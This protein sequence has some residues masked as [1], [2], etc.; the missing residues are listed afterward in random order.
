MPRYSIRLL[1]EF[2]VLVDGREVPGGAWRN[3]RAAD[4]VKLLA[5]EPGRTLHR[6]H[7]M[8]LLWPALT[9]AAAG[10]N[11][12]KAL[13]LARRALGSDQAVRS[14]G[15]LL[16]LGGGEPVEVDAARFAAAA[17]AALAGGD[18]SACAAAADLYPGDLLPA[19]RYEEWAAEPRTRLRDLHLAVLKGAGRWERALAVD[20]ADEESHRALMGAHLEAGRRREAIRQFERLRDA[21]REL[22]GVGPDPATVALYERVLAMEGPP[23]RPAERAAA[24]IATG[25]VHLNRGEYVR[26]EELA[27]RARDLAVAARLN[28]ELGDASTL[29]ALA[30]SRTGGWHE[31]FLEEFTA[32]LDRPADLVSVYDAN[33]CLAE[34]HLGGADLTPDAGSYAARLLALAEQAD[35]LP[36]RGIAELM[37][38]EASLL[39]GDLTEA[40]LRLARALRINTEAGT[41]SGACLCLERLAQTALAE[42]D[43]ARAA[44]RLSE[45]LPRARTAPMRSHLLVRLLGVSV[46]AAPDVPSAVTAVRRAERLLADT[47]PTCEACALPYRVQASIACS[48]AGDLPRA[49]RH[50]ADAER[51]AALWQ[52]APWSA[53]LWEARAHLRAAEGRPAQAVAFLR[54]AAL[55]YRTA[56]RPADER[57]CLSTVL[58]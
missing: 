2:T 50:L 15:A 31:L 33:L 30:R 32:L 26:A 24:L 44:S 3:R 56:A 38:G 49:R 29:M 48:R 20:P 23:P 36:G 43:R 37:L 7:V 51:I 17:R 16:V 52:C 5:L 13:H 4:L 39:A 22:M 57:R 58:T 1:G 40:G 47:P 34:Y 35:S 21:L 14:E 42:G 27:R 55:A 28:H 53:A 45:A 6:Q 9:G 10:A 54:E 18:P 25:L 19:D 12:R 11:L 41:V 8:G 46:E